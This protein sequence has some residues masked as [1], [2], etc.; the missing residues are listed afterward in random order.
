MG[1]GLEPV[2]YLVT[3]ASTSRPERIKEVLA[4]NGDLGAAVLGVHDGVADGDAG[5]D[6]LA[7]GVG[8]TAGT[9]SEHLT[10]LGLLLRGVGDH[11]ARRRRGLGAVGTDDD[12]VF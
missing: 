10:L 8:A 5:R 12:A 4:V 11:Q 2:T 9:G 1:D 3:V 7:G 6:D